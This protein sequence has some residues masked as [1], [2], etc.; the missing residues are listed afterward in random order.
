MVISACDCDCDCTVWMGLP[1]STKY[2][3]PIY[4]AGASPKFESYTIVGCIMSTHGNSGWIG[5]TCP[6]LPS[7]TQ[8]LPACIPHEYSHLLTKEIKC[9]CFDPA[10]FVF[11][12]RSLLRPASPVQPLFHFPF[13]ISTRSIP[14]RNR[15]SDQ[16]GQTHRSHPKPCRSL[17]LKRNRPLNGSPIWY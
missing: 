4:E 10:R 1:Q 14:S 15:R 11:L 16:T 8:L 2:T 6:A 7:S 3:E 9:S 12:C 13:S 17:G 5:L